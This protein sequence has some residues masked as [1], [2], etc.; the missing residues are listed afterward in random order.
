MKVFRLA[1]DIICGPK[2]DFD[3]SIDIE[4]DASEERYK[5]RGRKSWDSMLSEQYDHMMAK[6][7]NTNI[8]QQ[9]NA[10]ARLIKISIEFNRSKIALEDAS[11][12]K[13]IWYSTNYII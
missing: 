2:T 6:I 11:M 8:I 13:N 1:L 5:L 3:M 10:C 12:Q 9:W 7:G 4:W